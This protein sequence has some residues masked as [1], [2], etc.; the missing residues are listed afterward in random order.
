MRL[1]KATYRDREGKAR[2][3][4]KWYCEI[5]DH[6]QRRRRLPAYESKKASEDFGRK[7][8][9]LVAC[10]LC[11]ERPDGDLRKW[12]E[13]LS[14]PMVERLRRWDILDRQRAAASK[15]LREHAEDY[16]QALLAKGNGAEHVA[17]TLR[18][19]LRVLDGCRLNTW[20]DVSASRVQAFLADLRNGG[21][22]ADD[23]KKG[24][25]IRTSNA[26]LGAFKAF[27]VW[28]VRDGRIS[29]SPVE[30]LRRL[31]AKA[32]L[33]RKRRALAGTGAGLALSSGRNLGPEMVGTE[34]PAAGLIRL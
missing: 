5:Q 24:A 9:A 19:V 28:C 23:K 11:G 4:R 16:R 6:L 8:E 14:P 1:F 10:R 20:S 18:M 22:G 13:G 12:L 7:V 27:G 26:Y 29:E 15:P 30:H 31:N 33:K 2:K 34:E 17:T 25:S 32:D 21:E 3:S